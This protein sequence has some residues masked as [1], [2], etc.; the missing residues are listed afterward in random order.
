[1]RTRSGSPRADRPVMPGYGLLPG[2]E[3]AGLLPWSWAEERIAKARSLWV[4]TV[5]D[6]GRPHA[7]PVW[8]VWIAGGFWFSTGLV[9]VK[10][11]NLARSPLCVLTTESADEAVIIEGRAQLEGDADELAE[12]SAAYVAKYAMPWPPDSAVYCVVPHLAF[13]IIEEASQFAGSATRWHFPA[14]GPVS[15][16][17]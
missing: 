3:G 6:D 15:S 14:A 10:A 4:S 7:M 5:R 2:H 8:G 1:M 11:R 13:G 9:T 17:S 16:G 12:V